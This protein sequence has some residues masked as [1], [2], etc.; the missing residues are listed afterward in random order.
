MASRP[1]SESASTTPTTPSRT[2]S[3]A[4]NRIDEY[5][6]GAI[7]VRGVGGSIKDNLMQGVGPQTDIPRT[8]SEWVAG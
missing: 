4:D 2:V 6:K 8:A 5:Q 3:I 7:V 1:D